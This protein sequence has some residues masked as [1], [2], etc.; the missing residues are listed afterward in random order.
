MFLL[1]C[2]KKGAFKKFDFGRIL[3]EP[4]FLRKVVPME[5]HFSLTYSYTIRWWSVPIP[6]PFVCMYGFLWVFQC[7]FS[8]QH[9]F[10]QK[11][12]HWCKALL[13]QRLYLWRIDRCSVLRTSAALYVFLLLFYL[14]RFI[15]FKITTDTTLCSPHFIDKTGSGG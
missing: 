2:G 13:A 6:F 9:I 7:R 4:F 14:N 11:C 12:P 3:Y 10:L 1:C 15:S 8:K 5:I